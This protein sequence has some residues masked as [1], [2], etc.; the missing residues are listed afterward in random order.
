M[1]PKSV[2][3][4]TSFCPVASWGQF[5]HEIVFEL[6][7]KGDTLHCCFGSSSNAL[8]VKFSRLLGGWQ[9]FG[10]SVQLSTWTY[11]VYHSKLP[12]VLPTSWHFSLSLRFKYIYLPGCAFTEVITCLQKSRAEAWTAVG[13]GLPQSLTAETPISAPFLWAALQ[14]GTT[15]M[16]KSQFRDSSE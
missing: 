15:F 8:S 13:V 7:G 9:R 11:C 16:H 14:K 12:F 10:D 4:S 3:V 6:P 5:C 2:S 1:F